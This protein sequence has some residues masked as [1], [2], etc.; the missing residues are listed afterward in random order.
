MKILLTIVTAMF[1]WGCMSCSDGKDDPIPV[2]TEVHLEGAIGS[3]TRAVINS[4]YEKDLD[5]CF[6]RQDETSKGS[7]VY[8]NWNICLAKR[9]N[10]NGRR[11]IVFA[12]SQ[13]YPIQGENTRLHGYYPADNGKATLV[14]GGVQFSVDG[15]TD[16]MATGLLTGS[17]DAP[18]TLCTFR[19][20]LTQLQFVCYSSHPD[21]WG[22][23]KN[24]EIVGVHTKQELDLVLVSP[25]LSNVSSNGDVRDLTVQDIQDLPIPEVTDPGNA[26]PDA[27]GY[28]LLPVQPV[29]G[30]KEHP[31]YVRITTTKDGRGNEVLTTSDVCLSVEGGFQ[32]GKRHLI[33]LSF[34]DGNSIDAVSVGVEPWTDMDQEEIPV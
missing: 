6:A 4:G 13:L 33:T 2:P 20:L 29:D 21:K 10:G 11:P 34:T 12:E 15:T 27:Q 14:N 23:I 19:H 1:L 22:S 17:M 30:T 26:L 24:I 28:V 9:T 7:A 31:L 8:G 3:A 18:V 16:I 5:V 32:T 25:S